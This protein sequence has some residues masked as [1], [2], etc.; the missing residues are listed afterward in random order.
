MYMELQRLPAYQVAGVIMGE[1]QKHGDSYQ[2]QDW[3][4]LWAALYPE[5]YRMAYGR[6]LRG[7]KARD[8]EK[9]DGG[10]IWDTGPESEI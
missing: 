8:D 9:I 2:I 1:H 7:G 6:I 3:W 4:S 5:K 10:R